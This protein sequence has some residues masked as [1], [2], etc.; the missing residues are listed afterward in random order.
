M[1]I[2]GIHPR[3]LQLLK[4]VSL[5]KSTHRFK[6]PLK[7][8]LPQLPRGSTDHLLVGTNTEV[9]VQSSIIIVVTAL[10][11]ITTLPPRKLLSFQGHKSRIP[12]LREGLAFLNE[13]QRDQFVSR[14]SLMVQL[15][16]MSQQQ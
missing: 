11:P 16:Q 7:G 14:V 4:L 15:T 13:L 6:V 2:L 8:N 10:I 1:T 12:L 5:P 9:L 3:Q